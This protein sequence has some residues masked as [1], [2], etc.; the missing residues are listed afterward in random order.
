MLYFSQSLIGPFDMN[1][2]YALYK[3]RQKID[4]VKKRI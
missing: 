1:C 3:Y 2:F 4:R